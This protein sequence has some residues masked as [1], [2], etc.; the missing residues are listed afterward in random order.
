[1]NDPNVMLHM[2]L[3]VDQLAHNF[4]PPSMVVMYMLT[5]TAAATFSIDGYMPAQGLC[6]P[7]QGLQR[8]TRLGSYCILVRNTNS[9]NLRGSSV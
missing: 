2:N 1:M 8:V 4:F 7:G 3:I 5:P 9:Q 6:P